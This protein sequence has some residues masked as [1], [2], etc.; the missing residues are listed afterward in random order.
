MALTRRQ[1]LKHGAVLVTMGVALPAFVVKSAMAGESP[2]ARLAG[3]PLNPALAPGGK[4]SLLVVQLGGGNDGLNTLVPFGQE[5]YYRL[6]PGLAIPAKEALPIADGVGLHPSLKFL[7][8]LYDRGMVGVV[9]GVGYPNPN[10]SHFR[11]MEI[12]HTANP[13]Q[14]VHS[15][16]LGRYL[17]ACPEACQTGSGVPAVSIGDTLP[18]AFWTE[19]IMVPTIASLQTFKYQTD[20]RNVADRAAQLQAAQDVQLRDAVLR[21]YE[22]LLSQAAISAVQA[23]EEVQRVASSYQTPVTYPT[24]PF[25]AS[26]KLIAQILAGDLGTRI[27]YVSLGGFDTHANQPN[28]HRDLLARLDNGLKAFCQDL[29]RLGRTDDMI[30]MTFSEFGRRARQ[31]GSNGT[32]HGT[33]EP[34]FVIGGKIKG[35]MYGAYPSLSDLDANGDLKFN[36]DFRSVYGS[37]MQQWMGVDP[38]PIVGGDFPLLPLVR[39][40]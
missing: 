2:D 6:R 36:T 5:Q 12:W 26:L 29:D 4:R 33:A 37:V 28:T 34:M 17:E 10:R 32:D 23:S 25:G 40:A 21:P 13:S 30:I 9:Q 35:G 31:N 16:W 15:G 22:Q 24:D 11:S 20:P 8:S 18:G 19:R 14:Y 27:F 7:K 38:R 3:P 1:F 39:N